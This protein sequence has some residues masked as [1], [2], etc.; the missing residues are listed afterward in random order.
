MNNI[1]SKLKEIINEEAG[2]EGYIG[3]DSTL[4]DL[5]LDSLD[6]VEITMAVEDE[7]NIEIPDE[8]VERMEC[9]GDAVKYL[10]SIFKKT[11]DNQAIK[12]KKL[13][14][15]KSQNKPEESPVA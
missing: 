13:I 10:E 4:D 15:N 7:F 11:D 1:A 6:V 12:T 14:L 8:D 2:V 3:N 5:G 9:F